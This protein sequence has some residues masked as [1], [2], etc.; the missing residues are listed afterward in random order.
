MPQMHLRQGPIAS[1][2]R[3]PHSRQRL[4]MSKC[5]KIT[6][7]VHEHRIA[8]FDEVST[9][10]INGADNAMGHQDL[11]GISFDPGFGQ[12]S[13]D[14]DPQAR[15]TLGTAVTAHQLRGAQLC[16]AARR[17]LRTRSWSAIGGEKCGLTG[18]A[19]NRSPSPTG[20]STHAATSPGV[21]A[22]SAKTRRPSMH[23][24]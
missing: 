14:I 6:R 13:R 3:L 10:Q 20:S 19:R 4:P 12:M 15:A 2:E 16:C 17:A 22:L 5:L 9:T 1:T 7:V 8:R 23:R 24:H 11:L 21:T 18:C